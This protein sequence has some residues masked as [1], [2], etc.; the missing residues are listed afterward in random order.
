M[1]TFSKLPGKVSSVD[2]LQNNNLYQ[3]YLEFLVNINQFQHFFFSIFQEKFPFLISLLG[4][5]FL[6]YGQ[7]ISKIERNLTPIFCRSTLTF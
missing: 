4:L 7:R 1:C 6:S 2:L 3:L 5:Q